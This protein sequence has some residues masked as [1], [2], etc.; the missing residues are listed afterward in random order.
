MPDGVLA[1]LIV[2]LKAV[3]HEKVQEQADKTTK[4]V[5]RAGI[6]TEKTSKRW[7]LAFKAAGLVTAGLFA[8]VLKGG[9]ITA[10]YL[11]HMWQSIGWLADTIMEKAGAWVILAGITNQFHELNKEASGMSPIVADLARALGVLVIAITGLGIAFGLLNIVM[12]LNPVIFALGL[13]I[14]AFVLLDS[15]WKRNVDSMGL[16]AAAVDG[17]KKFIKDLAEFITT[18]QIPENWTIIWTKVKA[19]IDE[20]IAAI[21]EAFSDF[22]GKLKEQASETFEAIKETIASKLQSAYEAVVATLERMK[23]AL[24]ATIA[25]FAANPVVRYITTIVRTVAAAISRQA[26]G[27]VSAFQ[28][29]LVGERGPEMFV[30]ATSGGITP[31]HALGGGFGGSIEIR[32]VIELDGRVIAESVNKVM[33]DSLRRLGG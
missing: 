19:V 8:A 9:P 13:L 30:P 3:G 2:R 4:S 10:M 27:A 32:N 14:G 23:A 25:Y 16:F 17:A 21:K 22:M 20:K 29:Y 11:S 6:E 5:Q 7:G 26:G 12:G 33:A 1:E 15:W 28:P 24:R 18:G 31:A